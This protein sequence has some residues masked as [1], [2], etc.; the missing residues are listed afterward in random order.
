M[1]AK[2]EKR[3]DNNID[4]TNHWKAVVD[5]I[6]DYIFITDTERNIVN[7]NHA[8]AQ[9][10]NKH[11]G[12]IIGKQCMELFGHDFD[13]LQCNK[14]N[15]K[16]HIEEKDIKGETY[17]ISIFPFNHDKESLTIHVLKNITEMKR[18][19]QQLHHSYKLA[20]LGLLVSGIAHEINNPLT[21]IIAYTELL[22]MK[23]ADEDISIDLKKILDS[24]DRCKKIAEN[25]LIFSRQRTPTKSL[26][27][28]NDII[29][30]TIELRNYWLKSN[31][32]E[33]IKQYG[34]IP[35]IFVDSQQIQHV[36]LNI[37]LNA[38]QAIA[39]TGRG[40]GRITFETSYN[41]ASKV[42]T[43]KVSDNGP[44][45]P[46]DI[47]PKIFDP[48][49]STKSVSTGTGL[50]LS[51]SHGIIAEHGGSI[52]AESSDGNGAAFIVDLPVEGG[53]V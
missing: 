14:K 52:R 39:E 17:L 19:K 3:A 21:G 34:N 36:M 30:R 31:N 27:S 40:S 22:K 20:S 7:I 9:A 49:F 32:I 16:F 35:T 51:I 44:G 33:I 24:A 28:I 23:V 18:L 12:D 48:F 2:S 11:A 43:I 25:L 4:S 38:E 10:Y 26:E 29:D 13:C 47:M 53:G 42:V 6:T 15:G 5:G 45:I 46:K 41:T 8:M 1:G 50:G 37:L